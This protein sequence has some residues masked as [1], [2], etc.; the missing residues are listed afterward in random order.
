VQ[1]ETAGGNGA[2][3]DMVHSGLRNAKEFRD[4]VLTQR[5]ALSGPAPAN[6]ESDAQVE[7]LTEIRDSLARL[8]KIADKLDR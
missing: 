8:E 2:G 7:L 6:D 5:D 3:A 4:A 1:V